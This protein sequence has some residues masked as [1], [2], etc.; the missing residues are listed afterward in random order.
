MELKVE[1]R[2]RDWAW[3]SPALF[4]D[5]ATLD[6]GSGDNNVY[7]ITTDVV[8]W[9]SS[10]ERLASLAPALWPL[11]IGWVSAGASRRNNNGFNWNNNGF[12]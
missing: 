11:A 4:P 9:R 12:N 10:V 8:K 1:L 3:S 5:G 6:V 7:A 2:H